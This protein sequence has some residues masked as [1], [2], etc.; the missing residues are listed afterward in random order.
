MREYKR[1][2]TALESQVS[3]LNRRATFHDDHVK[4][5]DAWFAQLIDEISVMVVGIVPTTPREFI[6]V[7]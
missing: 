4:L 6:S 5:I 1:E 7:I 2:K 3:D